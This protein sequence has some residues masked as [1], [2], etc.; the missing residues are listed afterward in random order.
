MGFGLTVQ[1][2]V[3]DKDPP[4]PAV[5]WHHVVV[6]ARQSLQSH[7]HM[8]GSAG[9]GPRQIWGR[10]EHVSLIIVLRI[11]GVHELLRE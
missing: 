9:H 4:R 1:R 8:P 11:R 6:A 7:V 5:I 10:S 2:D 3:E